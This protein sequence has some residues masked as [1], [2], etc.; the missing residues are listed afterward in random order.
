MS[1]IADLAV[2]LTV[3]GAD[4]SIQAAY[5]PVSFRWSPAILKRETVQIVGSSTFTA[6]TPPSGASLLVLVL[7]GT[8]TGIITAKGVT[9]DTGVPIAPATLFKG[10]PLV[11]P[12]GASP[13]IGF[14]NAG[15]TVAAD[16]Y[17]V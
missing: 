3:R 7:T 4:G 1:A 6:L 5:S 14:L 17:W 15:S 9:G 2:D 10:F 11:L 13:T 12:L 16:L 8:P